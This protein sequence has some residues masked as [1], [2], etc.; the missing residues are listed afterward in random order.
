MY[1]KNEYATSRQLGAERLSHAN[2]VHPRH[3]QVQHEHI[4]LQLAGQSQRGLAIT[5]FPESILPA[6]NYEPKFLILN[7]NYAAP[8]HV[9]ES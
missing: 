7:F 2:A 8:G 4:G 1:R 5:I 6:A 3:G 9:A